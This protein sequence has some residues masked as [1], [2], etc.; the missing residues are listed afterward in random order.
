MNVLV[1]APHMDDEVLG[2]GGT[3]A[4]HIDAGD[5]VQVCVV[6]NRAYDHTYDASAIDAEKRSTEQAQ[7]ILGYQH[8]GFL[9]LPDEK[10]YAHLQEAITGVEQVV[11]GFEP[12]LVY[13]AFGGDLHQDHRTVAHA[14][15][16]VLRASAAPSVRRA[17]A[18]EVPSGTDQALPGGGDAFTPTVFVDIANQLDRKIKAMSA[19]S[20]EMREFPHPRSLDMLTAKARSRGAQAGLAAAEAFVLLREIV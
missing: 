11:A 16:I 12:E 17:L 19:Y 8:L 4:R 9:D 15:S 14:V 3:I 2:C 1:V 7:S 10:L 5:T 6:C 20:R 13:T 18:F